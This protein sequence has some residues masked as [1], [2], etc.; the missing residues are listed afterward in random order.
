MVT[1]IREDIDN[2]KKETEKT[3][4]KFDLWGNI[5]CD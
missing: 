1:K 2:L 3:S 5:D 4:F